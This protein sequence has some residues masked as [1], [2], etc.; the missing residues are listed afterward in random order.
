MENVMLDIMFHLPEHR[1]A[2]E[3][4]IDD[5][6]ILGKRN[7]TYRTSRKKKKA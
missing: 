6:V 2:K 3:C 5:Q 4:I 7:P 1:G